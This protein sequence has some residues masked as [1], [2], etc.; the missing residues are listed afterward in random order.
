MK[1]YKSDAWDE[2]NRLTRFHE[3]MRKCENCSGTGE[4][5]DDDEGKAIECSECCGYGKLMYYE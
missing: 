2:G 3:I 5:F 4:V 1:T